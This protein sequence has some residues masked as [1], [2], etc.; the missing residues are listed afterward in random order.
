MFKNLSKK[1]LDID[2]NDLQNV[3]FFVV[4]RQN[5]TFFVVDRHSSGAV[6]FEKSHDEKSHT[7]K[8]LTT[9]LHITYDSN[10]AV[11]SQSYVIVDELQV[12]SVPT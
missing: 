6:I 4:D 11:L 2:R 8:K 3:T 9:S 1:L 7:Y 10:L 12:L 5:V